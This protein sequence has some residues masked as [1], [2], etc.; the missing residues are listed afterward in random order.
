MPIGAGVHDWS[1]GLGVNMMDPTQII[2]KLRKR[3]LLMSILRAVAMMSCFGLTLLLI[4]MVLF[5]LTVGAVAFWIAFSIAGGLFVL[6]LLSKKKPQS[7]HQSS[8]YPDIDTS[9]AGGALARGA[10]NDIT[11]PAY[12]FTQIIYSTAWQLRKALSH[13]RSW[14]LVR[15]VDPQELGELM[16][17]LK[18]ASGQRRYHRASAVS[19]CPRFL[20]RVV[21]LEI[22]LLQQED[23][24]ILVGLN[25]DYD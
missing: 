14:R 5:I 23:G 20:A 11:A 8:L 4:Y 3:H 9:T 16:S 10:V 1:A 19:T 2:R 15:D 7:Y 22:V 25:R 17:E 12:A 24:E 21:E 18:F 13:F 6:G